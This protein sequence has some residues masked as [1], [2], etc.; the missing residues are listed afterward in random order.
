[1]TNPEYTPAERAAAAVSARIYQAER[2]VPLNPI[3]PGELAKLIEAEFSAL[4][5]ENA[6]L[7]EALRLEQE[8]SERVNTQMVYTVQSRDAILVNLTGCQKALRDVLHFWNEDRDLRDKDMRR[9]RQD[10]LEEQARA[11]L[12]VERGAK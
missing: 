11:A 5:A 8:K 2:N 7:R 4:L 3:Q 9:E 6:R 1:M 10:M 12:A